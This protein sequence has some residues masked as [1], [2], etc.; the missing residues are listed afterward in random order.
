VRA[1]TIAAVIAA[2]S[3]ELRSGGL[4]A[5]PPL[6]LARAA[7]ARP[8]RLGF[9]VGAHFYGALA[10]RAF[11]PGAIVYGVLGRARRRFGVRVAAF[12]TGN[13]SETLGPGE[14]S[15]TRFG[16]A[17]GPVVRFSPRRFAIDLH[18]E[19][20][21]AFLRTEGAGFSQDGV[22]YGFDPGIG[23]GLQGGVRVGNSLPSVGVLVAGWPRSQQVLVAGI[24]DRFEVP[25]F[26]LLFTAGIAFGNF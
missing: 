26:E 18:A 22:G 21:L 6:A 10:G 15:W 9:E 3:G 7:P 14:V 17:L 1:L 20:L 16:A 8:S 5:A 12:G 4:A 23:A 19:L 13:R 2:W 11:A 24:A 25:R